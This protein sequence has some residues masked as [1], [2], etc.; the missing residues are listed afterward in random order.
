MIAPAAIMANISYAQLLQPGAGQ[1]PTDPQTLSPSPPVSSPLPDNAVTITSPT[2]GQQVPVGRDLT[3]T[4]TS[5]ANPDSGCKISVNLN[6][7]KPLQPATP[8][9]PGGPNDYSQWSVTLT[10]NYASIQEGQNRIAAKISCSSDPN[11]KQFAHV[12]VTGVP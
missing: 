5:I 1:L 9:G 8:A 4:G 6:R 12:N 3:V 7:L 10:S 2:D 11:L